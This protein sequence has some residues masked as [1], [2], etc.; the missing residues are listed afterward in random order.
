MDVK[1]K[2][3]IIGLS[4]LF[5]RSWIE[6][7]ILEKL[8]KNVDVTFFTTYSRTTNYPINEIQNLFEES[9]VRK[10]SILRNIAWI[11]HRGKSTSFKFWL[12]RYYFSDFLWL[13]K[14]LPL[15]Q[16]I[17]YFFRQIL[18]FFG[19]IKNNKVSIFYLFPFKKSIFTLIK[20]LVPINLKV[21]KIFSSF[22][23]VIV[24]SAS[25][26]VYVPIIMK[27]LRAAG[28]KSFMTIE[29]WDNL[30]SKQVL[31]EKPDFVSV[32]GPID[33]GHAV[34]I[35]GFRFEQIFCLGLPKFDFLQRYKRKIG[36]K[37]ERLNL[38]YIGFHLP[39]NEIGFLN[40]LYA[41]LT[42]LGLRFD[43][44]YRPH[45]NAR[46]RL[47]SDKLFPEISVV[48]NL[49]IEKQS[50]L[51]FLDE[52]YLK[53]LLSAD[54]VIGP[55]TTLMIECMLLNI[56]CL[57]DVTSDSIHRTTSARSVTNYLHL[58]DFYEYFKFL[59]FENVVECSELI[60]ELELK[61]SRSVQYPS[62]YKFVPRGNS[63]F[64]TRLYKA[65]KQIVDN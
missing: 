33:V 48:S 7:N 40:D 43:L 51:P 42:H 11:A 39:H 4:P 16:R 29:N 37:Y 5:E 22:D 38:L 52:S 62:L 61:K 54:L 25:N 10:V 36:E 23:L 50:G 15:R 13:Q 17:I 65:I 28:I 59:A 56:P 63:D 45:P 8:S 64:S 44:H 47:T 19:V 26:E 1:P 21:M 41:Q 60:Q 34:N 46:K 2:V 18:N 24:H 14:N 32:M 58:K 3:A 6:T 53:D 27:S 57:M 49:N 9:H 30:T 20:R 12:K 35:H 31:F 55:P